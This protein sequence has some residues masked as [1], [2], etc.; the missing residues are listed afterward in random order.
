MQQEMQRLCL[1][2]S[3]PLAMCFIPVQ[4]VEARVIF[5]ENKHFNVAG[6]SALHVIHCDVKP[7]MTLAEF[8]E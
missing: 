8:T 1:A 7:W 6:V 5:V 3:L 2:A 4:S